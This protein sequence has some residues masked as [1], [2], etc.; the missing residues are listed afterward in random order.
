M[1]KVNF[2]TDF[3]GKIVDVEM[4]ILSFAPPKFTIS[5]DKAEVS[6]PFTMAEIKTLTRL[7]QAASSKKH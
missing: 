6:P 2:Q 3:R 4:E 5:I 1:H 7:A